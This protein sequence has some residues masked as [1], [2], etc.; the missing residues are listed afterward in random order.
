M[1]IVGNPMKLLHVKRPRDRH[2]GLSPKSLHQASTSTHTVT[3]LILASLKTPFCGLI[4][5]ASSDYLLTSLSEFE[6]ALR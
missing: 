2:T 5:L 6:D 4:L 1:A 3:M